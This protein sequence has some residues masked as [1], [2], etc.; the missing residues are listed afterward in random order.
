MIDNREGASRQEASSF[1]V[2][3]PG[4]AIALLVFCALMA[5][6]SPIPAAMGF[7][8]AAA[9]AIMMN[10]NEYYAVENLPVEAV[11]PDTVT[12]F[13]AVDAEIGADDCTVTDPSNGEVPVR[14][15]GLPDVS[16]TQDGVQYEPFAVFDA[17]EEGFYAV[18]CS[19]EALVFAETGL[20]RVAT[21][22]W[23]ALTVSAVMLILG[24]AGVVTGIV[25]LQ[26]ARRRR[27][28][29]RNSA[30]QSPQPSGASGIL[31]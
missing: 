3:R 18:E 7:A 29:L 21:T 12:L 22:A 15:N 19:G 2:P 13:A 4:G 6:S 28:A 10:F 1:R 9:K 17:D 20:H 8:Q 30:T 24:I 31:R 27:R 5:F 25:W 14:S 11:E 26:R 16:H 23:V